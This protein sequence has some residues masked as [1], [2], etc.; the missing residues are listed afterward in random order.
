ML[1]G[2]ENAD[3]ILGDNGEIKRRIISIGS[4]YPFDVGI[5]WEKYPPPFD[6]EVIRDVQRFD[7]VDLIE[8][9]DKI[10]GNSGNDILY[11][12]RGNDEVEGNE[13]DDELIGGLGSDIL[14]GGPGMSQKQHVFVC[15]NV[16]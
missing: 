5:I 12:Q 14:S 10:Y 11:G 3:V 15:D 7:D 8:G 1:K 9:D 16:Y 4:T 6:S 13:G 2:G